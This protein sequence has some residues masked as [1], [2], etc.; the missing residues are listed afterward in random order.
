MN[1]KRIIGI[2]M[3]VL[4][5][6]VLFIIVVKIADLRNAILLSLMAICGGVFINISVYLI[7]DGS[8]WNTLKV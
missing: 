5:F 2:I 6:T 4:F 8:K 1:I 7:T 3:M